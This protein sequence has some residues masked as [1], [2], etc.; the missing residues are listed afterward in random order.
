MND[1]T[2]ASIADKDRK[3]KRSYNRVLFISEAS[4]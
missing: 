3:S 4:I 1:A 2:S